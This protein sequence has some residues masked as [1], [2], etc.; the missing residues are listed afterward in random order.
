MK[1]KNNNSEKRVYSTPVFKRIKLD[2]EISLILASEPPAG[3][4]EPGYIGSIS[5]DS[6]NSDPFKTNLA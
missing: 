6:F 5:P 2:N 4:G 3:P 1:L